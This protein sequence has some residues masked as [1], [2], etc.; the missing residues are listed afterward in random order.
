MI[1]ATAQIFALWGRR[2]WFSGTGGFI[3][4]SWRRFR[5]A[6]ILFLAIAAKRVLTLVGSVAFETRVITSFYN[7][8]FYAPF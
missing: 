6:T 4:F 5:F 1:R 2:M 3:Q 7:L 8:L